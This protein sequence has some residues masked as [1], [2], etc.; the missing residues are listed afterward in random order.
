[1]N[2]SSLLPSFVSAA[3]NLHTALLPVCLV[4]GFGGLVYKCAAMYRERSLQAVFPYLVKLAVAFCALSSMTTWGP[5]ITGMVTDLSNQAGLNQS[6]ILTTF[7]NDL[8]QKFGAQVNSSGAPATQSQT[9]QANSTLQWLGNAGSNALS[10]F[11]SLGSPSSA[12]AK[13]TGT[14]WQA[15]SNA[16]TGFQTALEAGFVMICCVLGMLAMWIMSLL[17]Q[18][19]TQVCIAVS[20]IFLG[21][22]LIPPLGQM[23]SRFFTNYLAVCCW[24]IGWGISNLVTVALLNLALNPSNNTGL[25]AWNFFGGGFIWWIGVGL[26]ALFSSVAAPWL[27]TKALSA[28]ENPLV[29]LFSAGVSTAQTTAQTSVSVATSALAPMTGSATAA[30]SIVAGTM[31]VRP[32]FARRPTG[33][34]GTNGNSPNGSGPNG[35]SRL[36][37]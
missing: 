32:S 7:A 11:S 35:P 31:A 25:G 3:N 15:L 21:C 28:G 10:W 14:L 9:Q 27:V 24:P 19:L 34:G 13:A 36:R 20:P 16:S 26:W 8:A 37:A 4:L 30:G 23:A 1:M 2:L 6:G 33:G 29:S 17:Q 18:V 22:I 12:A 5:M